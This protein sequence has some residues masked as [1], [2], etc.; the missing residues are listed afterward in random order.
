MKKKIHNSDLEECNERI[1]CLLKEYNCSVA[2]HEDTEQ[3]ILVDRDTNRFEE[4]H[5]N[6]HQPARPQNHNRR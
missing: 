3:L 5:T 4:F 6:Q 1:L 2:H